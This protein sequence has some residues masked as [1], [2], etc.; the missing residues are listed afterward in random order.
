MRLRLFAPDLKMLLASRITGRLEK[1]FL[2]KKYFKLLKQ[3]KI[4][5]YWKNRSVKLSKFSSGLTTALKNQTKQNHQQTKTPQ[6]QK[7]PI[8]QTKKPHQPTKN[9]QPKKPHTQ[10]NRSPTVFKQTEVPLMISC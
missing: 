8:N 4:H 1:F 7:N 6:N 10:K 5:L 3:L 2:I 9:N